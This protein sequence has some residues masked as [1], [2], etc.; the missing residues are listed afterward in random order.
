M[1]E[2]M[3]GNASIAAKFMNEPELEA[4]DP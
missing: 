2:R 4:S 3:N 1:I